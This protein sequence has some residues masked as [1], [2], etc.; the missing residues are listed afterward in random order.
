MDEW[1]LIDA[2]LNASVELDVAMWPVALVERTDMVENAAAG[3][4]PGGEEGW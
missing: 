1:R 2:E 4:W 3:G